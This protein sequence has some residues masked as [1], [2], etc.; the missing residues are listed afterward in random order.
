MNPR[1]EWHLDTHCLGQRVL[2]FDRLDSTNTFTASLAQDPTN[3]GIVVLADEQSAGRGQHGRHWLCPP[4]SGILMSVL[5]FPPAPLRRPVVLAAWAAVAVC[6]M[7]S[8]SLGLEA[9]IKWP[10]DVF[11]QG[12]KVCGILIEQARGTIVGI[13]LNVNQTAAN[14]TAA[15]LPEASS[16]A[17]FAGVSL[18][19]DQIAR[20]LI[21][22]LDEEYDRLS[23]G[24]FASLEHTWRER[25]GLIEKDV[26]VEGHTANSRGRLR[27][28]TLYEIGIVLPD[29]TLQCLA[30]ESIRHLYQ[31]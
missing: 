14:L 21:Y 6:E 31:Q 28:V 10:N 26:L 3:A 16:L 19:R 30:P 4:G 7:I 1:E 22:Q 27:K 29:G 23:K 8:K 12:R 13:G 15:G 2:L 25:L 5:L 17:L 18:D 9:R 11:I 20:Q 24:D